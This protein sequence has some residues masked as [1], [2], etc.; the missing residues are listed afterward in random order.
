MSSAIS[1][2][3]DKIEYV[4]DM[5]EVLTEKSAEVAA[6]Q[7][8]ILNEVAIAAA[9]SFYPVAALQYLIDGIHSFTGLNW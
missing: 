5:A 3:S 4:S 8:P 7:A 9:D 6:T 2:G 1:D